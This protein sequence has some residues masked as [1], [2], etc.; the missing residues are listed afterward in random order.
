M[1]NEPML[2]GDVV[3]IYCDP[4]RSMFYYIMGRIEELA[5]SQEPNK[6]ILLKEYR[7]LIKTAVSY[8][9]LDKVDARYVDELI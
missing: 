3:T 1:T 5:E 4:M 7:H 8:G 9:D 2:I 6:D